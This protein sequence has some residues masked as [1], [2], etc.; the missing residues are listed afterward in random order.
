MDCMVIFCKKTVFLFLQG[1]L[2]LCPFLDDPLALV[3]IML[4]TEVIRIRFIAPNF[5]SGF[6]EHNN[7]NWGR[8]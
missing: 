7:N 3:P 6:V 4:I 8:Y 5:K 1:V 2:I